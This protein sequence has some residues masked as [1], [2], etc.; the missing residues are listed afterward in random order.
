MTFFVRIPIKTDCR[1]E[2]IE[3]AGHTDTEARA[4]QL[5]KRCRTPGPEA[6]A[7]QCINMQDTRTPKSE[8]L[9]ILT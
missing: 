1:Q 3:Y 6:R 8:P 2:I 9:D 7:A 4:A 5:K